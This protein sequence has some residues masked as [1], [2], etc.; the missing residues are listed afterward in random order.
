MKRSNKEGNVFIKLYNCIF[1]KVDCS[2]ILR[3]SGEKIKI[4]SQQ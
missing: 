4:K 2:A 1:L 3:D